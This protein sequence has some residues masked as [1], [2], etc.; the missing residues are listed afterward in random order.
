[1]TRDELLELLAGLRDTENGYCPRCGANAAEDCRKTCDLFQAIL[2]LEDELVCV[3]YTEH[4]G[5]GGEL[6]VSGWLLER[7]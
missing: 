1:M 3:N 4:L 5:G 2:W 6:E 7:G